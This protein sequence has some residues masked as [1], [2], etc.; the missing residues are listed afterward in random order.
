MKINVFSIKHRIIGFYN[1]II[2]F[3]KMMYDIGLGRATTV[4]SEAVAMKETRNI[5]L[6]RS[7]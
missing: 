3:F 1:L 2:E 5:S 4:R 7:E 6:R